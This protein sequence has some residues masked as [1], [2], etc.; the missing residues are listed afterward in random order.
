MDHRLAIVDQG[1]VSA[2]LEYV[3]HEAHDL[4]WVLTFSAAKDSE[5]DLRYCSVWLHGCNGVA[6]FSVALGASIAEVGVPC[7]ESEYKEVLLSSGIPELLY[8]LAR[9]RARTMISLM[10]EEFVLPGSCEF[11]EVREV[12]DTSEG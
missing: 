2:S 3:D 5:N 4:D 1:L 8:S 6:M 11:T 7:T 9:S 12:N 10:E